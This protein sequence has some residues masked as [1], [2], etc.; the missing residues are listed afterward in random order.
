VRV[1]LVEIA[2]AVTIFAVFVLVVVLVVYVVVVV[3][4]MKGGTRMA[5]PVQVRWTLL[6][7]CGSLN[8]EWWSIIDL[9]PCEEN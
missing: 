7:E 6:Y 5:R 4:E 2:V 9:K 3:L 8:A 1:F